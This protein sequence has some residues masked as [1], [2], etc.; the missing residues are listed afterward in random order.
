M[1]NCTL[2][3]VASARGGEATS[4]SINSR[5]SGGWTTFSRFYYKNADVPPNYYAITQTQRAG[6]TAGY[7]GLV[8]ALIGVMG[9]NA[10]FKKSPEV[11][12]Q[13]KEDMERVWNEE[14]FQDT[15]DDGTQGTES[16]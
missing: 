5:L 9:A 12:I 16:Y 10:E 15:S 8:A 3:T 7:F 11:L 4:T 2:A 6:I 14:G 1:C 13:E